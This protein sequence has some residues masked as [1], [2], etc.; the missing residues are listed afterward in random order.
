[1]AR[2]PEMGS[3][4]ALV[5]RG[6]QPRPEEA[7]RAGSAALLREQDALGE[8][9]RERSPCSRDGS[10]PSRPAPGADAAVISLV[11]RGAPL[12]IEIA[13][14]ECFVAERHECATAI[15][16]S[17]HNIGAPSMDAQIAARI[18]KSAAATSRAQRIYRAVNRVSLGD[19]TEI[20]CEWRAAQGPGG[21]LVWG[22]KL[23]IAEA[24]GAHRQARIESARA[25]PV[26]HLRKLQQSP[27]RWLDRNAGLHR[28]RV[29]V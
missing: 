21:F 13:H 12:R 1:M 25:Q 27:G 28:R 3:R 10:N 29:D 16:A 8:R 17:Q 5:N 18:H 20:E 9:I 11:L 7:K 24:S 4:L 23:Q 2:Q 22:R 6:H 14:R 15:A 26:H 19:P